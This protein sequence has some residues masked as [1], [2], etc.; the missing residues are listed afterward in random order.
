MA[1]RA[2]FTPPRQVIPSYDDRFRVYNSSDSDSESTSSESVS[3]DSDPFE[4]TVQT[5]TQYN[6]HGRRFDGR[7]ANLIEIERRLVDEPGLPMDH[8]AHYALPSGNKYIRNTHGSDDEG[9]D[10]SEDA[11]GSDES[12]NVEVA[13]EDS[14]ESP[15]HGSGHGY[16]HIL[17]NRRSADLDTIMDLWRRGLESVSDSDDCDS[18]D[19]SITS[20]E[21]DRIW[22]QEQY[23]DNVDPGDN[24]EGD[25]DDGSHDGSLDDSDDNDSD[26]DDS[27]DGSDD[28]DD[29]SDDSSDELS[30]SN[31]ASDTL[32]I[33]TYEL[34]PSVNASFRNWIWGLRDAPH[35]DTATYAGS[36]TSND[37]SYWGESWFWGPL[38]RRIVTLH[39]SGSV[40]ES[41][42]TYQDSGMPEQQDKAWG[43]FYPPS[44]TSVFDMGLWFEGRWDEVQ[45]K[46]ALEKGFWNF[47]DFDKENPYFEHFPKPKEPEGP[48][49]QLNPLILDYTEM[50]WHH[51]NWVFYLYPL[52]IRFQDFKI[53]FLTLYYWIPDDFGHYF[54]T[55]PETNYERI[56][57]IKL[58]FFS[59]ERPGQLRSWMYA[60]WVMNRYAEWFSTL[61][62]GIAWIVGLYWVFS[63]DWWGQENID[64]YKVKIDFENK[65]T[66][67]FRERTTNGTSCVEKGGTIVFG[68]KSRFLDGGPRVECIN[69]PAIAERNVSDL[70]RASLFVMVEREL[71]RPSG[72]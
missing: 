25:S 36:G 55:N 62:N 27:D 68:V 21:I 71:T 50:G 53:M 3:A 60:V 48:R 65:R 67:C 23:G 37:S 41:E 69:L 35:G 19:A 26:D 52:R 29:D 49:W 45:R 13:S 10:V 56:K 43:G 61:G 15:D 18:D 46:K 1:N 22:E 51:V 63:D 5:A 40:P 28:S 11:V 33:S 24:S 44:F 20:S 32:S 9:D 58:R 54:S 31:V 8:D 42:F 12:D 16:V 17:R 7:I 70:G 47:V 6:I 59:R 34:R 4:S 14:D 66:A 57:G 64:K 38:G 30:S 39:D 72:Q 2:P